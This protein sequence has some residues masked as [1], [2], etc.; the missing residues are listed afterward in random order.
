MVS[1]IN[2]ILFISFCL[3]QEVITMVSTKALVG[4]SCQIYYEKHIYGTIQSKWYVPYTNIDFDMLDKH[5][6]VLV[7]LFF[8]VISVE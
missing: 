5:S 3:F 6:H 8:I 1:C 7:S 4:A 2:I